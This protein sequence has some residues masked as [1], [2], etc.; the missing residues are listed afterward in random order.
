MNGR[1]S[2]W[3]VGVLCFVGL[4]ACS[5]SGVAQEEVI[6]LEKVGT[7][8]PVLSLEQ[9]L[10]IAGERNPGIDASR[11]EVAV[12]RARVTQANSGRMPQVSGSASYQVGYLSRSAGGF[13][14]QNTYET[15]LSG[16]QYLYGFGKVM[17]KVRQSR[18]QFVSSRKNLDT[19][20]ADVARDVKRAYFDVL[21]KQQLVQVNQEA[22]KTQTTHLEQARAFHK[23]G[24]RPM[25]DV[26]KGEVAWSQ[27]RLDL[28]KAE[29]NLRLSRVYL[30][31]VLGG[32][33]VDGPYALED[34]AVN[35][36]AQG[37][38]DPLLDQALQ[39]RPEVQS[40]DALIL[41]AR[42]QLQ[43]AKG[44]YWP[45]FNAL[46][47]FGWEDHTFPLH[48]AWMV[49]ANL[50]WDILPG[51]RTVGE[52]REARASVSV[53]QARLNQLKL[54]VTQEVS[55]AYLLLSEAAETIGT[56]EVALTNAQENMALAT[57]R[58]QNGVGDA[59]EYND[60]VLSLTT[61]RSDLVQARYSY[62]EARADLEH[63][64][65][66]PFQELW[67]ASNETPPPEPAQAP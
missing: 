11:Q 36:A 43:S 64:V 61:A 49:G 12:S 57:G 40:Q 31:N 66:I 7:L 33:P 17:G 15:G 29:Y 6:V 8:E 58:Y 67:L 3:I 14:Q 63:A 28:I 37:P 21:K 41:A 23:A 35:V 62:L 47:Q 52:V 45:T 51:L 46:G 30:E 18:E 16:Q 24:I 2:V 54:A 55:Q 42:G 32:P 50:T 34:V 1:V 59:I 9:V 22:L 65:G 25:I 60:A 38:M 44:G 20:V 48:N 13:G 56:A 39:G 10:E 53:L 5:R 19:S 26:T 4:L 27:A